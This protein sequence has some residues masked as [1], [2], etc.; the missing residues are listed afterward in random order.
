[1]DIHERMNKLLQ[2]LLNTKN[3]KLNEKIVSKGAMH[4]LQLRVSEKLTPGQYMAFDYHVDFYPY[5]E[6]ILRFDNVTVSANESQLFASVVFP[7]SNTNKQPTGACTSASE[8]PPF[9]REYLL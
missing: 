1:M 9:Y 2:N 4:D 5:I 8:L 7:I 3:G 6:R